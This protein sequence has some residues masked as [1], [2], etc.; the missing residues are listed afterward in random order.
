MRKVLEVV[1]LAAQVATLIYVIEN[2]G[3]AIGLPVMV[4]GTLVLFVVLRKL[5]FYHAPPPRG[6]VADLAARE[7]EQ[8][9]APPAGA[10]SAPERGAGDAEA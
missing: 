1:F 5:G 2:F 3:Y 8:A 9:A 4:V 6:S 10:P 7:V